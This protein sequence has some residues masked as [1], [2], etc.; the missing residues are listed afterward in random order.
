MNLLL[1]I[2]LQEYPK[3]LLISVLIPI[4]PL[5]IGISQFN[6][7]ENPLKTLTGLAG[8]AL[9]VQV[10][11]LVCALNK[12]N[13]YWLYQ[14]YTPI[15]FLGF[16]YIYSKWLDDWWSR[17]VFISLGVGFCLFAVVNGVWLQP[18]SPTNLYAVWLSHLILMIL[19]ISFFYR[20]ISEMSIANLERSPAF[21]INTSIL[22][23]TAGSMLIL[24]LNHLII[25]R[26]KVLI[27]NVWYFH[28]TF[29]ILHYLLFALGLWIK[30]KS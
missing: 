8:L 16:C 29:N 4:V 11:G 19:S 20:I 23:Y 21:W 26:S 24:G 25:A 30:P 18:L 22:L 2:P 6:R 7:F 13:N 14:I 10:I 3:L 28:S 15:A 1:Q 9:L 17:N 27:D 5:V 12:W